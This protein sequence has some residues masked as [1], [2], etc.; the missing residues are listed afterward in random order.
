[1]MFRSR[2]G[3]D[4]GRSDFWREASENIVFSSHESER[5]GDPDSEGNHS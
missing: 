4:Q 5:E 1:M 3:S 2:W